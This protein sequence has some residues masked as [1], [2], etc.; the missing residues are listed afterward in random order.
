MLKVVLNLKPNLNQTTF[1]SI[2]SF[3][4]QTFGAYRV[5]V[6]NAY[7]S[8]CVYKH[9]LMEL[10]PLWP[11]I[12]SNGPGSGLWCLM[13][14]STIFQ[15]YRGSQFYLWRKP[16]VLQCKSMSMVNGLICEQKSMALT[17]QGHLLIW[18]NGM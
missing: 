16:R 4:V 9:F 2:L 17:H 14:L 8:Y 13:P 15:L 3:L 5:M 1:N 11:A 10:F 12:G 6:F 18:D 7:F